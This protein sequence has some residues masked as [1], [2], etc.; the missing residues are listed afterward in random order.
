LNYCGNHQPCRNGG[1]CSNVQPDS[2]KCDCQ[3]GYHGVSCEIVDDTW[4]ANGGSG[5]GSPSGFKCLCAL[6]W[7]GANCHEDIDECAS[8]PCGHGGTCLN[9]VNGF[10]CTCPPQWTGHTCLL[11]STSLI[12][13]A[14]G[15]TVN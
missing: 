12:T 2:F 14:E 8:S 3:K 7:T 5:V 10:S 1:S 11:A 4:C 6:G 9:L 13:G 15:R